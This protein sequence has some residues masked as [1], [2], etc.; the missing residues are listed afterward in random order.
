MTENPSAV[1][2][3]L[4]P[5]L[6][7]P[8]Y[9]AELERIITLRD[10]RVVFVRPIAPTD[11]LK[12][13]L[14]IRAADP[15]TLFRRFFTTRPKIDSRR[16]RDWTQLDYRWRL[17]LVAIDRNMRG[18]GIACYESTDAQKHAELSFLVQPHWQH[19][20]LATALLRL[21][22]GTARKQGVQRFTAFYLAGNDAAAGLF[23]KSG[24]DK[25]RVSDGVVETEKLLGFSGSEV[26]NRF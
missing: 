7:P 20:G 1:C 25:P 9:P 3:P 22:E 12:L 15:D 10:G 18:V 19:A 4:P 8:G 21:L 24:F 13:R 2:W 6:R 23:A 17:A 5:A 16:L 11:A 26:P 14:E